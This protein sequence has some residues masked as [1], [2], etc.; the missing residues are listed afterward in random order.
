MVKDRFVEWTLSAVWGA[1][2]SRRAGRRSTGVASYADGVV[3]L[4]AIGKRRR[5]G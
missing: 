1:L 5:R 4:A 3:Q 2:G